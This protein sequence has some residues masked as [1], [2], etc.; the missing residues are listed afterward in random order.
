MGITEELKRQKDVIKS[1]YDAVS[2]AM[3]DHADLAQSY[4]DLQISINDKELQSLD[5][6]KEKAK[7][8]DELIGLI[9]RQYDLLKANIELEYGGTVA[10]IE[11]KRTQAALEVDRLQS[12][13]DAVQL[14]YNEQAIRGGITDEMQAQL[15]A[16][17]AIAENAADR[18]FTTNEILNNELAS[19]EA[20]R[21]QKLSAL[22]A[23]RAGEVKAARE[24][25]FAGDAKEGASALASQAESAAS[26]ASS[27]SAAATSIR[28]MASGFSQMNEASAGLGAVF[29]GAGGGTIM[30]SFQ[31]DSEA[32]EQY[33]LS[34]NR[35]LGE[36][37]T[38]PR[39]GETIYQRKSLGGEVFTRQQFESAKSDLLN[40]KMEYFERVKDGFDWV[41]GVWKD[42]RKVTVDA[43]AKAEERQ[44]LMQEKLAAEK[45]AEQQAQEEALESEAKGASQ[46]AEE[47][48]KQ[49]RLMEQIASMRKASGMDYKKQ[50][51][52]AKEIMSNTQSIASGG[53]N[54]L[55][56]NTE[57]LAAEA[58]RLSNSTS[59]GSSLQGR[60]YSRANGA[61]NASSAGTGYGTPTI[62]YTGPTL[63]FDDDQYV[64]TDQIP[65]LVQ[66]VVESQAKR[67]QRDA[68]AR[69]QIRV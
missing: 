50:L 17:N 12:M 30:K 16:A 20:L 42:M 47:S 19:A 8:A 51:E 21:D 56:Y 46:L 45:E 54:R 9:N 61:T 23:A 22:D 1:T 66:G 38:D 53:S 40:D 18:L 10:A 68:N 11:L 37:V 57:D 39:T 32:A 5:V 25:E 41:G 58:K 24:K 15:N 43:Q 2:Q 48:R 65:T 49:A 60:H 62:N 4:R 26:L 33:A 69:I 36:A 52:Q 27:L 35:L 34:K 14:A 28:T 67:L 55:L 64:K 3:Q 59:S 29:G 7:N 13:R 31:G 6:A 44:K 63:V